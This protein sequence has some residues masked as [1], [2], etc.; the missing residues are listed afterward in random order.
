MGRIKT[1]LVKRLTEK[2]LEQYPAKF[3]VDLEA[4]KK[5]AAALL[6]GASKKIRNMI[7]GYATRI[8]KRNAAH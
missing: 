5:S 1:K 3:T 6:I 8:L 7:A 2:L 4:N